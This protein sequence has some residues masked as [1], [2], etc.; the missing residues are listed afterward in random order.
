MC[1]VPNYQ[2]RRA[3]RKAL[4]PSQLSRKGA[5]P[6][7]FQLHDEIIFE[8]Y[9]W[10]G[11]TSAVTRWP[12]LARQR[13]RMMVAAA[14]RLKLILAAILLV[15]IKLPSAAMVVMKHKRRKFLS[16]EEKKGFYGPRVR[17]SYEVDMDD[18][19]IFDL[20]D[21]FGSVTLTTGERDN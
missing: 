12:G 15:H 18:Q 10:L 16:D 13:Y 17:V 7:Q 20:I 21:M 19:Y 14:A 11:L 2:A 6:A 3:A 8:I 4:V 5:Q 9:E 1:R